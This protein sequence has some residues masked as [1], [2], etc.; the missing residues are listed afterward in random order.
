MSTSLVYAQE[1]TQNN[2]EDVLN[3]IIKDLT[4]QNLDKSVERM[5]KK[6]A[7]AYFYAHDNSEDLYVSLASN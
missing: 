3:W 7:L 6:M 2:C 4:V 1:E 5:N